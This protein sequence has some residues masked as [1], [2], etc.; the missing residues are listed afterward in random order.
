[1]ESVLCMN[2]RLNYR[3]L[4]SNLLLTF[5]HTWANK[6]QTTLRL[7]NDVLDRNLKRT[8]A[9]GSELDVYNLIYIGQCIMLQTVQYKENYRIVGAYGDLTLGYNNYLYLTL[10]GRND[11]TS[12]LEKNQPFF[13]LSFRQFK[14]YFFTTF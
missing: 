4:N 8:S 14:L 1:M 13:L 6:F 9:E 5:D 10:T 11:W 2:T 12:S 3:Q 7:G